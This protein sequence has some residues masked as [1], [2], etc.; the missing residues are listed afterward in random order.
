MHRILLFKTTNQKTKKIKIMKASI[1]YTVA[2][3]VV[4]IST[5]EIR[6]GK[7]SLGKINLWFNA[8]E[9]SSLVNATF[10]AARLAL[11]NVSRSSFWIK[12]SALISSSCS[13]IFPAR[14]KRLFTFSNAAL[15]LAILFAFFKVRFKSFEIFQL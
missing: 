2:V 7:N 10:F 12:G 15:L 14:S 1:I 6:L 9:T 3:S 5:L 13:I 11:S 8:I 4:L